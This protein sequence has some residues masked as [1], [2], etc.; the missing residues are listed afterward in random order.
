MGNGTR[1]PRTAQTAAHA[2]HPP[3]EL[4]APHLP[5]EGLSV[6]EDSVQTA[7]HTSPAE[8]GVSSLEAPERKALSHGW[9]WTPVILIWAVVAIF[10]AG[11]IGMAVEL[12][13]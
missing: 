6:P 10:L 9:A 8:S 5:D 12:L 1:A 13:R 4:H 3:H 7:G 2:P 11:A